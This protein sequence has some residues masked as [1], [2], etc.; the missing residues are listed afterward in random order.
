MLNVLNRYVEPV[1]IQF[2]SAFNPESPYVWAPGEVKALSNEAAMFCRR[3]SIVKENPITG[4]QVRALVIQGLD[5]EFEQYTLE[6][7]AQLAHRGPELLDRSDMDE[8]AR[9]I[10]YVPIANPMALAI[11]RESVVTASH[12]RRVND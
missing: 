12:A 5:P 2:D 10:A 1:E 4:A 6:G 8:K 11:E 9:N 7:E 3:K